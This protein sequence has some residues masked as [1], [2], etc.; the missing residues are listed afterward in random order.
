MISIEHAKQMA[1]RLRTVLEARGQE[2]THSTA[3]E[4]VAQQLGYKNW[5]TASALLPRK[6]PQTR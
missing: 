6:P 1:K 4:L 2:V 3:L 5:N